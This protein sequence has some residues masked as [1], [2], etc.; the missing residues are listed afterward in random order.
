[1]FGYDLRRPQDGFKTSKMALKIAKDVSRMVQDASKKVRESSKMVS[2]WVQDGP[3]MGQDG[4][5]RSQWMPVD[6]IGAKDTKTLRGPLFWTPFWDPKLETGEAIKSSGRQLCD[7][8][9]E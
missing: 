4:P 3:K 6:R 2:G 7:M 9:R 5:A 8:R 1:M